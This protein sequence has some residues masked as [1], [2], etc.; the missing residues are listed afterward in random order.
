MIH[1][2]RQIRFDAKFPITKR[3]LETVILDLYT[4]ETKYAQ[5]H[6]S[7][8]KEAKHKKK[9]GGWAVTKAAYKKAMKAVEATKL[10]VT[11]RGV[12][13]FDLYEILLSNKA[14]KP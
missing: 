11:T 9:N 12:K 6:S 7:K 8:E 13:A 14:R 3:A 10:A 4:M 2:S 5:V 1:A